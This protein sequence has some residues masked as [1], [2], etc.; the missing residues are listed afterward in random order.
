M[1][2]SGIYRR[3]LAELCPLLQTNL[4]APSFYPA[5]I[6]AGQEEQTLNPRVVVF[7]LEAQICLAD[8]CPHGRAP[9]PPLFFVVAVNRPACQWCSRQLEGDSFLP[10]PPSLTP[11]VRYCT[12]RKKKPP[13]REKRS[14]EWAHLFSRGSAVW[15][16]TQVPRVQPQLTEMPSLWAAADSDIAISSESLQ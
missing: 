10:T 8:R 12:K 4:P 3:P 1:K 5:Q 7:A 14:S 6:G 9:F 2:Q 15:A 13:S 16:L 11:C